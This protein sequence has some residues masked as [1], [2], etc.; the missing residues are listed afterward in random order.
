MAYQTSENQRKQTTRHIIGRFMDADFSG[1][2]SADAVR[3][4][5]HREAALSSSR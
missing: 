2:I 4:H 5:H 1:L 3:R